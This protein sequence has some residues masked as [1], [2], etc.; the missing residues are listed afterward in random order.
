MRTSLIDVPLKQ[1]RANPLP[2]VRWIDD[3]T[4][5]FYRAIAKVTPYIAQNQY[6]PENH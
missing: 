1:C 4:G 3:S 6:I 2:L 5:K